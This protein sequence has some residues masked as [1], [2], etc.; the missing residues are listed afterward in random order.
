MSHYCTICGHMVP[1]GGTDCHQQCYL[2]T[3]GGTGIPTNS[4]GLPFDARD[5]EISQLKL[6]I[7]AKDA[8]LA[9]K[10]KYIEIQDIIISGQRKEIEALKTPQSANARSMA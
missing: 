1:A 8:E 9:A 7:E 10:E 6:V 2:L 4:T 5:S 3:T